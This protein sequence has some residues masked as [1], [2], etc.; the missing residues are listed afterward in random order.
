MVGITFRRAQMICEHEEK[1][2]TTKAVKPLEEKVQM[3]SASGYGDICLI[4]VGLDYGHKACCG[5]SAF[6]KDKHKKA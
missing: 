5:T 6:R 3:Q 1:T 2:A 4:D